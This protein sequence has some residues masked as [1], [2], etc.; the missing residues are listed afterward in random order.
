VFKRD[1][2]LKRWLEENPVIEIPPEA[3]KENDTD[4]ILTEEE[5]QALVSNFNKDKGE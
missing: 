5:E 3:T 4:W 2:F 1:E